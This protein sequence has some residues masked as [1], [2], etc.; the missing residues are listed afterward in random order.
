LR[1]RVQRLQTFRLREKV[2]GLRIQHL[3]EVHSFKFVYDVRVILMLLNYSGVIRYSGF[4]ISSELSKEVPNVKIGRGENGEKIIL[5]FKPP[6]TNLTVR[7]THRKC[8]CIFTSFLH[9]LL[10]TLTLTLTKL[11]IV[12]EWS[13]H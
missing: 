8:K 10:P 4:R 13:A 1:E 5:F 6:T 11:M 12:F 9:F 3:N 7:R 2:K